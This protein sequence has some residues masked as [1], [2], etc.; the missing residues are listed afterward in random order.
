MQKQPKKEDLNV[1]VLLS[2]LG[3]AWLGLSNLVLA[4]LGLSCLGLSCPHPNPNLSFST[5][6]RPTTLPL[7]PL[8]TNKREAQ[9]Q[10][11]IH[12]ISWDRWGDVVLSWLVMYYVLSCLALSRLVS[13]CLV[14]SRLILSCLVLSCLGLACL[15][16]SWL[17]LACLV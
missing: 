11:P 7:R 14:S 6:L 8:F 9:T 12:K 17:V 10:T 4:C 3:L 16:L 1:L 13:S 15:G 5:L 2:W